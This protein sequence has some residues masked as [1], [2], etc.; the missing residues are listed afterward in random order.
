MLLDYWPIILIVIGLEVALTIYKLIKRQWTRGL[1]LC[2]TALELIVLIVFAVILMNP[3][4]LNQ[5]FIN[6]MSN[7]LTTTANQFETGLVGGGIA[8]LILVAVLNIYEG[9]RKS[10]L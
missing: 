3:N 5:E 8:C 10:R 1:A 4:V 6:Y 7:L 2:N 9:Y